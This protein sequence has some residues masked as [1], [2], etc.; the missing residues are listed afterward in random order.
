MYLNDKELFKILPPNGWEGGYRVETN[1]VWNIKLGLQK[2]IYF[3][4]IF[5]NVA[6]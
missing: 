5:M 6:S 2:F 1:E 4:K 3:G